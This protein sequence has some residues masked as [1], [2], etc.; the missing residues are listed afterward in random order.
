MKLK[1][2][3]LG[4]Q[5]KAEIFAHLLSGAES[6]EFCGYYDPDSADN[7][8]GAGN[9]LF[10]LELAEKADVFMFD[11]H[12]NFID[13]SFIEHF[14]RLGKHLMFDGFLIQDLSFLEQLSRLHRESGNCMHIA[15]I[16]YNKPLYTTASQ[17]IRKPR[18][19]K[20]EKECRPPSPGNFEQW[21][22]KELAQDLDL[23]IRTAQSGIREVSAR[24]LFLFGNNPD[25]LNIHIEFDNDAVC[26]ISVGRAIEPGTHR[27][28]IF[29]QD[30]LFSLDFAENTLNEYRP[31]ENKDQLSILEDQDNQHQEL[32]LIQRPVV[33][34]DS[35]KME[36][37]NFEENIHKALTPLSTIENLVEVNQLTALITEKVQRR[38]HEV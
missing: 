25:L 38:Y 7:S 20:L 37:R 14:V 22:F 35:W 16:L 21:L 31:M 28:K 10:A 23:I 4:S 26:H 27:M 17:F 29:Q 5:R 15:N 36:L 18:F 2:V 32:T 19:I 1:T 12:V 9:L 13:S 30:R 24:P 34:F 3:I 8:D 6:F 11:R 33:P